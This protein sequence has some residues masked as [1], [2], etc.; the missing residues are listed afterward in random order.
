MTVP[1]LELR[2]VGFGHKPAGGGGPGGKG[3]ALRDVNFT[4]EAGQFTALLGV[5]GAGKSTLLSVITRLFNVG[6]GEVLVCGHSLTREPLKA[7]GAMGVVFQQPTLDLDLSVTQ[8]LTYAA[9]LRGMPRREARARI[10]Q[11]LVQ[12]ELDGR[13]NDRVRAL[14][15]GHRRRVELARA[16]L[17]RPRLLI[18][19]EPTVGLDVPSRRALVEHVHAICRDDGVAVLWATHLIDEIGPEDHVVVLHQGRI[20]TTGSV[21]SVK[22]LTEAGSLNQA[23]H[24]LIGQTPMG[25]NAA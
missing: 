19:D 14:N 25:A 13:A 7:L 17:H 5:N 15:G 3:F 11:L 10:E 16:L 6:S 2:N 22:T 1:A 9:G 24:T 4:V 21:A 8:N 18:L 20:L 23:F 12:F